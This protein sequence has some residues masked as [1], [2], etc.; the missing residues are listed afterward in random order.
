VYPQ[1]VA[2]Q[3]L[4]KVTAEHTRDNIRIPNPLE[5]EITNV[6]RFVYYAVRVVSRK[7]IDFIF[8]ELLVN[9]KFSVTSQTHSKEQSISR[10]SY[11]GSVGQRIR[12]LYGT[13]SFSTVFTTANY[14]TLLSASLIQCT[15]SHTI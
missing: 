10:E 8:A 6:G 9:I 7:V 13:Q 11:G 1:I 4:S 15:S 3:W 14:C 2:S 12:G 5:S